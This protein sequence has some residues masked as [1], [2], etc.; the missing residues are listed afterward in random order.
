MTEMIALGREES[1]FRLV[2]NLSVEQ[3]TGTAMIW[4]GLDP[5]GS[6]TSLSNLLSPSAESIK[7][8]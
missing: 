3:K 5:L 7:T 6:S 2:S 4:R 8:V 1:E